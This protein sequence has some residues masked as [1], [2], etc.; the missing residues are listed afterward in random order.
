MSVT[1]LR[2]PSVRAVCGYWWP[3]LHCPQGSTCP[4]G[5]C[6]SGHPTSTARLSTPS[7]TNR[8]WA[9]LAEKG[10][11]HWVSESDKLKFRIYEG[12]VNRK[13]LIRNVENI[14][15]KSFV[16]RFDIFFSIESFPDQ[17]LASGHHGD[18]WTN[19]P[20]KHDDRVSPLSPL[21]IILIRP[22]QTLPLARNNRKLNVQL[23][24]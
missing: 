8:W 21:Y 6:S 1:S 17:K 12:Q 2:A 18:S 7:P 10:L 4:P 19:K 14:D 3:R 15:Y 16:V 13:H 5:E 22:Q 9:E 24:F 20:A 11:T 23:Y